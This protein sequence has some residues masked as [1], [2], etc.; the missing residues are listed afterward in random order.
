MN[1]TPKNE[2]TLLRRSLKGE[3]QVCADVGANLQR[4]DLNEM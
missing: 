2:Y 3:D 4:M 1:K